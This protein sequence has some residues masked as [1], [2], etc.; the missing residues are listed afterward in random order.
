IP[1]VVISSSG[2][3]KYVLARLWDP[4]AEGDGRSKLLVWGDVR[5]AYH[6]DVLQKAKALARPLGLQVTPLGG[7][8]INHDSD[9]RAVQVYGYSAA[10]GPAPH[11]VTAAIIHKWFPLYDRQ[12]VTVSYD[13]Y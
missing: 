10:F 6:N 8:R 7:G 5:A 1:Q 2:T 11:E 9:A 12:S 13:G 4:K 3:F